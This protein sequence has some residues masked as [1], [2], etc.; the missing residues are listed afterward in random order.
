M[1]F[2]FHKGVF[3]FRNHLHISPGF[4]S[5]KKDH[6]LVF[7]FESEKWYSNTQ[8]VAKFITKISK[9]DVEEDI[10]LSA[11]WTGSAVLSIKFIELLIK[12]SSQNLKRNNCLT[13]RPPPPPPPA[14]L[15]LIF[16]SSLSTWAVAKYYG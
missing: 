5:T 15:P 8:G 10:K 14:L 12:L 9:T 6:F 2:N 1:I 16:R 7:S 4:S 11:I 13:R 3:S